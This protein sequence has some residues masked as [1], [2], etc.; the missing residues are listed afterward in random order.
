MLLIGGGAQSAA[1]QAFAPGLLDAHVE[2]PAPAEYV[3]RGAARQ[4]AWTLSGAAEPPQWPVPQDSS[5]GV[6]PATLTPG[7]GRRVRQGYAEVLEAAQ[8]L[9]HL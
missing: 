8:P 7:N 4:A 9:L 2:V 1:V 3:A 5:A 6:D